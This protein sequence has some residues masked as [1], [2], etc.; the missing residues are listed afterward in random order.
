MAVIF[1]F[2]DGIG[3]GND[4]GA[5]PFGEDDRYPAFSALSGGK[6][7]TRNTTPY[8]REDALFLPV[9]ACL[10][11]RGL[12]QSGTGQATLFSG[13]NASK[14]LGRHFGP[15]PHSKIRHLLKEQS[16]FHQL[17]KAGRSCY[18]MN[19]FP[20]S[21]I[22]RSKTR[23]RWSCCTLMTRSAG[24]VL[25]S[26]K[27]IMNGTAITADLRQDFWKEKLYPQVP[28]ITEEEAADR[29]LTMSKQ[30]DLVLVE[31][32]LTDMAGH[33]QDVAYAREMLARIDRL[34][35]HILKNKPESTTLIVT[36]DHGNLE[37]LSVKGHTL[38]KVPLFVNGP[39]AP[40]F[41]KVDDLSKVTP[42]L[43][44]ALNNAGY[45]AY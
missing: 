6:A 45:Q 32:Y 18:F 34:M 25:N 40:F 43:V 13:V 21:Y 3:L 37:D 20:E 15:W 5:N 24:Q 42:A 23:N 26:L 36:S 4:D 33:K 35:L 44:K 30:V 2:I 31:Y 39:L 11:I 17:K 27:E 38:N 9:D 22:T 29:V 10:G 41:N 1:V 28:V 14:I 8:Q 16:L 7:M 19:A 12:P